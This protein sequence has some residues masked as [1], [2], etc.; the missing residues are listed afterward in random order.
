[1]TG[2]TEIYRQTLEHPEQF[3]AAAAEAI[4]WEKRWDRV[5]DDSRPPFH[6]RFPGA[7]LNTC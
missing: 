7:R 2:Y 6:R 3:W 5:L 1:M 4:D